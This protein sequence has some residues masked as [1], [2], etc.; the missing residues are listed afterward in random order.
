MDRPI[1]LEGI[2]IISVNSNKCSWPTLPTPFPQLFQAGFLTLAACDEQVWLLVYCC[3]FFP[4]LCH[5]YTPAASF[6]QLFQAGIPEL[7]CMWRTSVITGLLLKIII[8]KPVWSLYPGIIMF[9]VPLAVFCNTVYCMII[10]QVTLP[11]PVLWVTGLLSA[12]SSSY[13]SLPASN[14]QFKVPN[15]L[16]FN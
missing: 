14:F 16:F 13:L 7:S 6:P 3:N 10:S 5:L 1:I 9:D 8:P 15:G 11:F 12:F 4:R 2:Y